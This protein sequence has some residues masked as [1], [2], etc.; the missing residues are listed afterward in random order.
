ME[1]PQL[2][3]P[4]LEVAIGLLR[5]HGIN[6][7]W[8][9]N[10]WWSGSS[11][12]ELNRSSQIPSL[13]FYDE[14]QSRLLE[15]DSSGVSVASNS[16]FFHVPHGQY[17]YL[18]QN[19][20][21]VKRPKIWNESSWV[22]RQSEKVDWL[23]R[24]PLRCRIYI[25]MTI[26]NP[27]YVAGSIQEILNSIGITFTM[28]TRRIQHDAR[29]QTVIW[30]EQSHVQLAAE[31]IAESHFEFSCP[32]PPTTLVY[33]GIGL[34]D[35]PINGE[36]LG[37][38]IGTALIRGLSRGTEGGVSEQFSADGLSIE[39]PWRLYLEN[40]DSIEWWQF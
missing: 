28:K 17:A 34:A 16:A 40:P 26:N 36:S 24:Q 33:R 21:A 1:H 6:L 14:I 27:H 32:P 5:H 23:G 2:M 3:H 9:Y 38:V 30:V 7:D 39:Y 31:A 15:V 37:L 29:D 11:G 20:I 4:E 25:P 8:L 18:G 12:P 35:H 19:R 13:E 10:N 22:W